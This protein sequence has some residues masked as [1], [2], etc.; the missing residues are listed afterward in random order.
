MNI[1]ADL[2]AEDFLEKLADMTGKDL[3][4]T[5]SQT[6]N[7]AVNAEE[8]ND[9]IQVKEN[10]MEEELQAAATAPID[11]TPAGNNNL[12]A[13]AASDKEP[14]GEDATKAEEPKGEE[15]KA[16]EA[17]KA[18][19]P[20]GEKPGEEGKGQDTKKEAAKE[21]VEAMKACG[22]PACQAAAAKLEEAFGLKAEAPVAG[23]MGADKALPVDPMAAPKDPMGAPAA[24]PEPALGVENCGDACK[25]PFANLVATLQRK[26]SIG[27]SVWMIK[28]ASDNSEF[29][30][31]N[32]KAAFGDGLTEEDPRAQ[33]ATS[34]QFGRDV[35]AS[36]AANNVNDVNSMTIAVLSVAAKYNP[37]YPSQ[38]GTNK[39][40]SHAKAQG[41]AEHE[42]DKNIM[43]DQ[44][45]KDAKAAVEAPLTTTA[46]EKKDE[47][48]AEC[49]KEKSDCNC[50]VKEAKAA[51]GEGSGL[52]K[53]P[54]ADGKV[55]F[56]NG[57]EGGQVLP[58][59]EHHDTEESGHAKA[60]NKAETGNDKTFKMADYEAALQK[61]ASENDALKKEIEALRIEAALKD[62]TAKVKEC[63]SLM[64]N[65]GF[66]KA[67]EEVR[68]ASLKD[69]LSIEA[70]NGRAMAAA[71]EKQ[72]KYLYAMS[73]TQLDAY[74]SSLKGVSAPAITTSASASAPLT[75][76]ASASAQTE[77]DR[78]L[79]VLGWD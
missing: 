38:L 47:K 75:I 17:P 41:K 26:A 79:K 68:V 34:E 28:N 31:F 9:G 44:G 74:M 16:P 51:M 27:D 20:E 3:S 76:K 77:E 24:A 53:K 72:A 5:E 37:G 46:E 14:K 11:G 36:M 13:N 15:P 42:T 57:F 70:S 61:K 7:V 39:P 4:K 52:E 69:G 58:A 62:K 30:S 66:I 73:T 33:Y 64:C 45:A 43:K 65:K 29:A 48:C 22:D 6:E 59:K 2:T 67:D 25:A 1:I 60:S 21:A 40:S 19:K 8:S 56:Y 63:V 50:K 23:P 71:I 54:G 49:G 12:E 32:V 78:L 18:D 10:N 55:P 35:V